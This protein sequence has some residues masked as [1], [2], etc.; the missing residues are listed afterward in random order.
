MK[1]LNRHELNF[2]TTFDY[3]KNKLTGVNELSSQF[4][5]S[6]NINHGK[7]YILFP[8]DADIKR[9]HE[10]D[11]GHITS[12]ID[13]E[14]CHHVFNKIKNK[15]YA[16]IFDDVTV[17]TSDKLPDEFTVNYSFFIKM[18]YTM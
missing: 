15:P 5:K 3:I 14:I 2:E 12:F 18:K 7:F 10:F 16:S 1:K 6:L 4:L 17:S 11:G 8:E 13:K 9:I